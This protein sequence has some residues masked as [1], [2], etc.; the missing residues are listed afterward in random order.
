MPRKSAPDL[1][2]F[3][4]I[5]I[6]VGSSSLVAKDG[7][8]TAWLDGLVDDIAALHGKGADVLVVSSGAIAMGRNVMRLKPGA[9]H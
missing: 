5:V 1:K 6:K 2:R 9:G 4:R 7:I 8:R 3:K